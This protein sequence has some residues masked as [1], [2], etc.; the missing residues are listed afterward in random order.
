M[1]KEVTQEKKVTTEA[2]AS[3]S[4]SDESNSGFKPK[5]GRTTI[6][7][8]GIKDNSEL[9]TGLSSGEGNVDGSGEKTSLQQS[10]L[11]AWYHYLCLLLLIGTLG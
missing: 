7:E 1:V 6:D 10:D 4:C 2:E 3:T 9:G 8:S 11:V 5:D